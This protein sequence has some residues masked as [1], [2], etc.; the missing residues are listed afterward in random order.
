MSDI[1]VTVTGTY[2]DATNTPCV[3]RVTFRPVAQTRNAS[4]ARIV[5]QRTV[6]ADLDGTGTLSVTLIASD[7][8][9]WVSDGDVLYEVRE[10]ITDVGAFA[11]R[12]AL[13]LN[14]GTVDLADLQA[15]RVET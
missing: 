11:Y 12:V 10:H 9:D 15:E 3:G 7:D 6:A 5:T 4:T 13:P 1:P 8:Q 14:G 2:V